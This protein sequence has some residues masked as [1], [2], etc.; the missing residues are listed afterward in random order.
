[1]KLIE[2]ITLIKV[3]IE[4]SDS[5]YDLVCQVAYEHDIDLQE[6]IDAFAFETYFAELDMFET[7]DPCG[8]DY[9]EFTRESTYVD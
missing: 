8:I 3:V 7:M 9:V 6:P 1:M 5:E 2:T 4:L